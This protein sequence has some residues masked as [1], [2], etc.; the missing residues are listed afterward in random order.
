MH[1]RDGAVRRV[2]RGFPGEDSG[3]HDRRREMPD[4]RRDIQHG[5][6]P[7]DQLSFASYVRVSCAGLINYQ[8]RADAFIARLV[9]REPG[10]AN[11]VI[12]AR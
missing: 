12:R 11:H 5:K 10:A 8:L 6:I 3:R 7:D 9:H 2:G 4:I 1:S